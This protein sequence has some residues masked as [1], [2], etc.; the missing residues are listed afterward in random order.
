MKVLHTSILEICDIIP[1]DD[2]VLISIREPGSGDNLCNTAH[3]SGKKLELQPGWNNICVLEFDDIDEPV[4]H[5]THF[6]MNHAIKI[7]DFVS[8]M[9]DKNIIVHCHAGVSRSGAVA[10]FISDAFK[11]EIVRDDKGYNNFVYNILWM[12]HEIKNKI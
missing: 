4:E 3:F 11:H 7:I 9:K 2:T 5:M 6:D 1:S 10:K 8:E 12:A